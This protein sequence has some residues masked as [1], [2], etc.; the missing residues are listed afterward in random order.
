MADA[1]NSATSDII[2]RHQRTLP[3]DPTKIAQDLGIKVYFDFSMGKEIAGKIKKISSQNGV[4][5]EIIVNAKDSKNRQRFTIA[6]EIAHF[7]LH[8][9]LI[10]DEIEDSALYR[11]SLGDHLERQAN[12]LA[13]EILLPAV[14]IRRLIREIGSVPTTVSALAARF[15]VSEEAMSIRLRELP[16]TEAA[17]RDPRVRSV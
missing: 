17:V 12:R 5:Y 8:R 6:H 15:N 16:D 13:A 9:D 1:T 14:E 3:V 10:G 11:S 4:G 7:L 2:A